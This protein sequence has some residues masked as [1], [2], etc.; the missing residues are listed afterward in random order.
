L[1]DVPAELAGA[2]I[3]NGTFSI[4]L[5][6]SATCRPTGVLL[7]GTANVSSA[8]PVTWNNS[9]SDATWNTPIGM[10][11]GNAGQV[12]CNQLDMAMSWSSDSMP[13]L[14]SQLQAAANGALGSQMT[15]GLR[16]VNETDMM[17]WMLFY[18]WSAAFV[19]EY[20]P[21]PNAP[22]GL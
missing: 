1:F 20:N 7:Y 4:T 12:G 6:N 13:A 2:Q 11:F 15:F 14:R 18:P 17:Q 8:A 10:R 16:A 21:A 22:A 19:I 9:S 3:V 5:D